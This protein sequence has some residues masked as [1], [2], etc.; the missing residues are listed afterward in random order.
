MSGRRVD[1]WRVLTIN[2]VFSFEKPWNHNSQVG[3]Q[4]ISDGPVAKAHQ[5]CLLS[6][7]DFENVIPN[8]SQMTRNTL[9]SSQS[10][11]LFTYRARTDNRRLS[12]FSKRWLTLSI[13]INLSTRVRR[14]HVF[15]ESKL[16]SLLFEYFTHLRFEKLHI[17]QKRL[18]I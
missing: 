11:G 6:R 10:F 3:Q 18:L 7:H 14:Q 9:I 13:N 16:A 8:R 1:W 12:N 5:K 2:T 4:K 17:P 15:F